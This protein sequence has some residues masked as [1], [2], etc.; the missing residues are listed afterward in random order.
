MYDEQTH[1]RNIY[2]GFIFVTHIIP[3]QCTDGR[4]IV[5]AAKDGRGIVWVAKDGRGIGWGGKI[6][7]GDCPGKKK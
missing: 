3:V 2:F 7:E 4:E 6:R 5:R 1:D